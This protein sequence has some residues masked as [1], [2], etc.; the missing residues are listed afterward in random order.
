MKSCHRQ[1]SFLRSILRRGNSWGVVVWWTC[2]T[3]LDGRCFLPN[4]SPLTLHLTII[5]LMISLCVT[6]K[7]NFLNSCSIEANKI[8]TERSWSVEVKSWWKLSYWSRLLKHSQKGYLKAWHES[9]ITL[10]GIHLELLS[11]WRLR[12]HPIWIFHLGVLWP[13]GWGTP[14]LY[15]LAFQLACL[16]PGVGG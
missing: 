10:R 8:S 14:L 13:I 5:Y 4:V 16:G 11:L 9:F 1:V 3:H 12:F 7:C 6:R 15:S 2:S